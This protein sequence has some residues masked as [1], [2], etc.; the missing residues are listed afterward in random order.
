MNSLSLTSFD[1]DVFLVFF[2]QLTCIQQ[3]QLAQLL[4]DYFAGVR[5][6]AD[7]SGASTAIIGPK[8]DAS[9]NTLFLSLFPPTT[10]KE[11]AQAL[12]QIVSM[13]ISTSNKPVLQ[14]TGIWMQ[15]LGCTSK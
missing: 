3:L 6:E 14:S 2:I 1:C 7:G 8:G 13:A 5:L 12:V 11:R 15:Q 4:C 10:S 9:R